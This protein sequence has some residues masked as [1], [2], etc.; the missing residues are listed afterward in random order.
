MWTYMLLYVHGLYV[1]LSTGHL[2]LHFTANV[3]FAT[4]YVVVDWYTDS[5]RGEGV[6]KH[7]AEGGKASLLH[8]HTWYLWMVIHRCLCVGGKHLVSGVAWI[9]LSGVWARV[10]FMYQRERSQLLNY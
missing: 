2:W 10:V 8:D 5:R 9:I 1:R 3:V 6:D 4:I 7:D